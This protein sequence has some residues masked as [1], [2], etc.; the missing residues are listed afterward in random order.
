[1]ECAPNDVTWS[2]SFWCKLYCKC[3][4]ILHK[5]LKFHSI[6]KSY[7]NTDFP[8]SSGLRTVNGLGSMPTVLGIKSLERGERNSISITVHP[9]FHSI[10][11]L[12][13]FLLSPQSYI[14]S[15]PNVQGSSGDQKAIKSHE[16]MAPG[17]FNVI[18]LH[19]EF[20]SWLWDPMVLNLR[21]FSTGTELISKLLLRCIHF[22]YTSQLLLR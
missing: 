2:Y 21:F 3:H 11:I 19:C 12:T 7:P 22:V 5:S 14:Y 9:G 1:M 20:S 17:N 10:H 13:L 8:V 18:S 15:E 6:C 4:I 16:L